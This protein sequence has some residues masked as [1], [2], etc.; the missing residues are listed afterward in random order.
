MNYFELFDLPFKA[1][2]D[3]TLVQKKY[4]QLQKKFHPDFF[5]KQSNEEQD[6]AETQSAHINRAYS[7][8]KDKHKTL[9]YF[10]KQKEVI[11]P[12]EKYNLPNDFLMEMLEINEAIGD[13]QQAGAM[14][15]QWQQKLEDEVNDILCGPA[16]AD[17]STDELSRL[18]DYY[19]K[20][21]YLQRIL[22]RLA[23]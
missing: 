12:D 9:E 13:G 16:E 22:D 21:K 6:D 18:K 7:I 1:R 15:M 17:Y 2:I 19:Y 11:Q 8:F 5:T 14:V 10:L 23:D 20:K 4:I 3:H